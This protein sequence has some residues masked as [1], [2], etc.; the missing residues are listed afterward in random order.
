MVMKDNFHKTVI[1]ARHDDIL[2]QRDKAHQEEVLRNRSYLLS[3]ADTVL[4]CSRQNIA[5]RGH[6]NEVGCVSVNGV[7]LQENDV[8]FRA[9]LRY[10]IRGGDNQLASF[11]KNAKQNATYHSTE[12]QNDL[13]STAASLI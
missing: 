1:E 8:N 5:L 4:I 7:E 13:I 12:V 10:R 2:S 11:V 6:R 3:I 9:L